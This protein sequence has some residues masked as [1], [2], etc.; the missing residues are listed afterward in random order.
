[1]DSYYDSLLIYKDKLPNNKFIHKKMIITNSI[2]DVYYS[3]LKNPPFFKKIYILRDDLDENKLKKIC[4]MCLINGKI[5]FIPKYSYFFYSKNIFIK[6]DNL[7]YTIPSERSV[8]FIIIGFQRVG[9]TAL[10]YNLS[11]HPEL[12]INS[13]KDP[14]IS[15]VHFFDI[16]WK[17]GISWYKKQFN[18]K[19]KYVGEKTPDLINLPYTFPLIQSVNPYVKLIISLRN[20]IERAY[21][22]WKLEQSRCKNYEIETFEESIEK[23]LKYK[24]HENKTFYTIIH[25]FL[26]RGLYY[27][28][29]SELI[30][31]FPMQNILI[32]FHE[33]LIENPTQE[34]NK[35][36]NFLNIKLISLTVNKVHESKNTSKINPLLYKNLIKYYE[37][38]IEQLE[39]LLNRKINWFT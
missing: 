37:K 22:A 1:M 12:Y 7:I 27:K 16:N 15:E 39:K 18:Y 38:D 31:W 21:S 29:I 8:D 3:R 10:A 9:S 20:P 4:N 26:E 32:L 34:Y 35:I 14:N 24:K 2:S 17:R 11:K 33:D 19:F 36:F 13:N 25:S 6:K 30:K 23:E 28:Y 5:Y